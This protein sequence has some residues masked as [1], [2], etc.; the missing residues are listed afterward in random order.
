MAQITIICHYYCYYVV[1]FAP[2]INI[3]KSIYNWHVI[4]SSY[5]ISGFG[6]GNNMIDP[7]VILAMPFN[8]ILS[9][10][11]SF[12][13]SKYPVFIMAMRLNMIL[14]MYV[15]PCILSYDFLTN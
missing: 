14:V 10:N 15:I 9:D 7:C 12:V 4:H 13:L 3:R 2:L 11:L 6:A 8:L 1:K 5:F